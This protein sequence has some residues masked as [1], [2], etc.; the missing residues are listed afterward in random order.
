MDKVGGGVVV[1]KVDEGEVVVEAV[2]GGRY[3]VEQADVPAGSDVGEQ[4]PEGG[5]LLQVEEQTDD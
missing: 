1:G 5:V 3:Q 2:E 4:R